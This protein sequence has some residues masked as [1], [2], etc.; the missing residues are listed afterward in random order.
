M[1]RFPNEMVRRTCVICQ[2]IY[3]EETQREVTNITS[4]SPPPQIPA[5][6]PVQPFIPLMSSALGMAGQNSKN[7]LE[8]AYGSLAGELVRL[9][10]SLSRFDTASKEYDDCLNRVQRVVEIMHSMR[11]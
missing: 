1:L 3:P 2:K 5:P 6:V 11:K 8:K 10:E 9:T 7:M 4:A